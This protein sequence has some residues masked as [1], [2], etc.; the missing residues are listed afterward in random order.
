M[1]M[2][3]INLF[4][5]GL[6]AD[7]SVIASENR[8]NCFYE[9]RQS[10]SGS[11]IMVRGT[12]GS[13]VVPLT[14]GMLIAGMHVVNGVLYFVSG[15]DLYTVDLYGTLTY[16]ASAP[17]GGPYVRM[18]DNYI[19]LMIV[20][21]S[22]GYIYD[23]GA[24]TLTQIT[25]VNF[26][27]NTRNVC[28]I[29]GRFVCAKRNTREFYCSA[30]LDGLTWTYGGALPMFGTKEQ[31]SDALFTCTSHNG[32]LALWGD[33]TVEFWQ[34][35]GLTPVPFQYIQGTTQS[36]GTKSLYSFANVNDTTYFLGHGAQGGWAVYSVKGYTVTKVSTSDI[37]DIIA[38]WAARGASFRYTHGLAYSAHGHDFY[39]L[40]EEGED[41]LLLDTTTGLWSRALTGNTN[42]SQ[43]SQISHNHNAIM[44]VLYQGV[45]VFATSSEST[46]LCVFDQTAY[47]DEGQ[48]VQRQVTTKRIRNGGNE[49]AITE[50]VLIMDTGEVP[51]GQDY[52]IMLEVSR[53]GG[54]TFG[55]PRPRT[56]GL[57]G[58][59]REPR[60][61]WDR[62]GSAREFVLRFTMTDSIP[63]VIAGAEIETSVNQ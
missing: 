59:Y 29:S 40:T 10:D 57:T 18:A 39:Q 6:H 20:D 17:F 44:A 27:S 60:V 4:G 23:I 36:Y 12:P 14:Q 42:N 51:V 22:H 3:P 47:S 1:A 16:L 21:G 53:D 9:I 38:G 31:A 52:K 45:N 5:T 2:Q 13:Y 24:G 25:D 32:I 11:T 34:D 41:S 50:L 58:Q 49:F 46:P 26:P 54:R 48:R 33:D 56:L 62:L 19:Q 15:N 61:K 55:S 35:A 7:S 30:A 37:D 63:F 8:L 43:M 28:F